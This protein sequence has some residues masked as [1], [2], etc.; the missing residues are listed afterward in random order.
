MVPETKINEFVNRLRATGEA[1]LVSIILYGYA[2]A[3]DYVAAH[4]DVNLL[5]LLR[6]TS[7]GSLQALVPAVKWWMEQKHRTPLVM[8]VE[9]LKRSADV[10]SIELLDMRESYRVLWGEDVLGTLVVPVKL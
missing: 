7:F 5:C 1:H 9:E 8:G 3:G 6:E 4:S 10:F 2:A